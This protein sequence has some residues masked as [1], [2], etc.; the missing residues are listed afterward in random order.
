MLCVLHVS[1]NDARGTGSGTSQTPMSAD[2]RFHKHKAGAG[3]NFLAH[4]CSS[5]PLCPD[6]SMSPLSCDLCPSWHKCQTRSHPPGPCCQRKAVS[7]QSHPLSAEWNGSWDRKQPL[8]RSQWC[9]LS[10]GHPREAR[11]VTRRRPHSREALGNTGYLRGPL[12]LPLLHLVAGW[13]PT[14]RHGVGLRSCRAAERE[15]AGTDAAVWSPP[16]EG[17]LV[18]QARWSGDFRLHQSAPPPTLGTAA[19]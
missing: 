15:T 17:N 14:V 13:V 2:L 3:S 6:G 8:E 7:P 9:S 4:S 12:L 19:S 11:A 10:A 16:G 5:L 18:G 1:M